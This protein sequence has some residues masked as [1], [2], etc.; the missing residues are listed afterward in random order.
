MIY[1]PA[2]PGNYKMLSKLSCK[3]PIFPK[4]ENKRSMLFIDN[5][6]EFIL[7]LIQNKESGIF[8][9][10][11]PQYI[12]TSIIVKEIAKANKKSVYLSKLAGKLLNIFI[13]NTAIYQKVF[14]DLYY[15]ESV[16]LYKDNSYQKFNLQQSITVTERK[17]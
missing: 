13:G 1:G 15:E 5:L 10:Q 16:S 2:C 9:P 8:H 6:C 3:S 14:G 17:Q 12:T 4:I 11:D 7:Q